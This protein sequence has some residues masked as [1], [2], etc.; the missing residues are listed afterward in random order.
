VFGVRYRGL[1]HVPRAGHQLALLP[2][3]SA[4][5]ARI[6][7]HMGASK[8]PES[9]AHLFQNAPDRCVRWVRAAVA[10]VED[11][12]PDVIQVLHRPPTGL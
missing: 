8:L 9:V 1:A 7:R 10:H 2:P 11:R 6:L 12:W 4:S 5:V 3:S